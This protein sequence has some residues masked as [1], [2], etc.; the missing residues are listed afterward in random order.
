MPLPED[1]QIIVLQ[2][3]VGLRKAGYQS[4][5]F[6]SGLKVISCAG[7]GM[8]LVHVNDIVPREP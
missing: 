1:D 7:E 6:K 5:H 2:A 4:N 3:L 8:T